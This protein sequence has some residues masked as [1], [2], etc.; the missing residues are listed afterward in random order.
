MP[1]IRGIYNTAR[2]LSFY[3]KQQGVVANNIANATTDGFKVDRLAAHVDPNGTVPVPVQATDLSQ[4]QLRP[5]GRPLDLALEGAGFL[6]V[7]T[8]EGERLSRGGALRLDQD[9]YLVDLNGNPILGVDGPILLRG[10]DVEVQQDGTVLV[11][12]I[13]EGQLRIE[14]VADTA[15]L[16]K[17]GNSLFLP[18]GKTIPVTTGVTLRQGAIEEANVDAVMEM[19]DLIQI[20][21]AYSANMGAMKALDR[22]LATVTGTVG[23]VR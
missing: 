4:G 5:T 20:Q 6:V 7:Q 12:G 8:A 2:T 21:R 18:G 10:G 19:V 3:A 23:R 17:E 1:P 11:D 13:A 22:V 9:G 15:S 14:T 16:Q